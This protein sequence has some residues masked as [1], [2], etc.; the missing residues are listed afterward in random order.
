MLEAQSSHLRLLASSAEKQSLS[1][2]VTWTKQADDGG[3]R[4]LFNWWDKGKCLVE[5]TSDAAE[6]ASINEQLRSTIPH[7]TLV[8]VERFENR[9]LWRKYRSKVKEIELKQRGDA[10]ER[11]LWHGTGKTNPEEILEHETA[12]DPRFSNS[13][14]YG[15]GLYL[16][17]DASYS[18]CNKEKTYAYEDKDG[19]RG[20]LI[21]CA[22]LGN[23]CDYAEKIDRDLRMPPKDPATG[24]LYDSVQ[25]G[26]HRPH[27]RGL[28]DTGEPASI[29]RVVY[30]IGQVY[31]EYIVKYKQNGVK[32]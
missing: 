1:F 10:D 27:K 9:F 14:F 21:V 18:D 25:G 29:I 20:L 16:A 32:I 12:L 7:A 8:S 11:Q 2:P 3:D 24:L 31:P 19:T 4:S 6:W 15:R 28:G 5:V 22:V 26:P 13:G 23:A 17:D 30:D